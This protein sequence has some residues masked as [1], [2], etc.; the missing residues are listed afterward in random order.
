M[1][2]LVSGVLTL[3]QPPSFFSAS[4]FSYLSSL[5]L[6]LG[7]LICVL[8]CFRSLASCRVSYSQVAYLFLFCL[9]SI[10]M[11]LLHLGPLH[12][13]AFIFVLSPVVSIRHFIKVR[14]LIHCIHESK[15][16]CAH[17][18]LLAWS[19]TASFGGFFFFHRFPLLWFGLCNRILTLVESHILDVTYCND[20]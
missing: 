20:I 15:S 2:E 13:A 18:C 4:L 9:C 14:C 5:I 16:M 7:D 6:F 17:C 10:L 1:Q 8:H 12:L 19:S 3:S 11:R